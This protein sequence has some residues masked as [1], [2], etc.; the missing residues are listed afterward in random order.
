MPWIYNKS[1]PSS[2]KSLINQILVCFVLNGDE[3]EYFQAARIIGN[4][5]LRASF[6]F[7]IEQAYPDLNSI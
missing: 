3:F 5:S 7:P 4:Y 1:L 6:F 2:L